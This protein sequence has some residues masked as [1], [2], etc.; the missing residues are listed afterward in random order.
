VVVVTTGLNTRG[1]G[2]H[3]DVYEGVGPLNVIDAVGF[4]TSTRLLVKKF[5]FN[6]VEPVP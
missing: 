1:D 3:D 2:D 5:T 4:S 6:A